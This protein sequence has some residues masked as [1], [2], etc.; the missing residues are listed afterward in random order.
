MLTF[1]ELTHI[2]LNLLAL[3]VAVGWVFAFALQ[4]QRDLIAYLFIGFCAMAAGWALVGLIE[5][6]RDPGIALSVETL[7]G[8][9]LGF[10]LLTALLLYYVVVFYLV[11]GGRIAGLLTTVSPFLFVGGLLLVW[12]ADPYTLN[13]DGSLTLNPVGYACVA[14]AVLYSG[15]ALWVA[16]SSDHPASNQLVGAAF[17]LV[18]AYTVFLPDALREWP[19]DRALLVAAMIATGSTL[20]RARIFGPL[21]HLNEE[22]QT[23]NRGLQQVINDLAT[24]KNR[25]EDLNRELKLANQY[26]SE[27]LANISH[28]LRTP[29]NS[30]LGYSDLLR[31]GVY[32]GLTDKQNDRVHKIY[33]NGRSLLD[34]ISDILDLNKIDAGKMELH[35]RTF[36]ISGVIAELEP[37]YQAATA[38]KGLSFAV[39]VADEMPQLYGDSGRI[40][41]ALNNL[42]ENAVKF[43]REGGITLSASYITVTNG[44]SADLPLPATGWLRDG[45]WA[46]L[47]VKDTGIG[48]SPEHQSRIFD[49]FSQADGSRT[50]EFGGTGLGL[51]ICRRLV[52]M[53]SGTV[54]LSSAAGQGSTFFVALPVSAKAQQTA[55]S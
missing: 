3:S 2:L 34:L 12:L 47:A 32:G 44:M 54:W 30:I 21:Q 49:D 50:R 35:V 53:H 37:I 42:L 19:L 39:Q 46:V 51:A 28:E 16:L 17:L 31:N 13:A 23:T 10:M 7:V 43:T 26:K 9:R 6:A 15:L 27:F 55:D 1:L 38:D 22:L 40:Q 4:P 41:Q 20:F 29:L 36:D 24:E 8:L 52:E 5:A 25:A 14:L 18:V 45:R 33:E 48:I 11:P